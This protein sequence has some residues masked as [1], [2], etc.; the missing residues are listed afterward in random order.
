MECLDVVRECLE[1]VKDNWHVWSHEMV[2]LK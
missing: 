2:M 1:V